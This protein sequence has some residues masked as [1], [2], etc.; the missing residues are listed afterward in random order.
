M[1]EINSL[2]V[3]PGCYIFKDDRKR[4]IYVGKAKNL[5]KRVKC[6]FQKNDLDIKT[7]SMLSR[8]ESLDFV[9]TDNE[10]EAL[11]LENT[12]IK[13]HQPRYNIRLKDAKSHSYIRLTHESFPRIL[14]ARR[15]VGEGKFYGPFV[16]AHERDYVLHFL[17]KTFALRTCKKMPKKPCLRYHIN[18]CD[19]PCVGKIDEKD[20]RRKIEKAKMVLSGKTKEL[21]NEMNQEMSNYSARQEFEKALKIRNELEAIAHL[22]ESQNMQ[23]EKKFN[24]D[25]INYK[26]KNEKVYLILFNI[27][28][29]ALSNKTEFIFDYYEGFFEEF[30]LQYYS[31]SPIPKEI[32]VPKSIDDTLHLFLENKKGEKVKITKPSK[33]EKKQLLDLVL[34]NIELSFFSDINKVEALKNRLKLNEDPLIIECFDIS[35]LSGSSTVGSMVQFRNGKPDK[36][37]YR[38]FKIRTVNGIDDFAAIAE[39]VRRRYFRLKNEDAELPQLIIIDGGRGQLNFALNELKNLDLK[40]PVVSIAKHFEEIYLPGENLP[41]R[42]SDKDKALHFIQEIRDEAHRF[43][44]KYNRLL[45][46][47]ELIS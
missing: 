43:A 33:G 45:R 42:L 25:I 31:D 27:Y 39:V 13:K 40:I 4:I 22:T 12:L 24:E 41:L 19:A 21:I 32:I 3:Y 7:Q 44:I 2:P 35:H 9:V 10:I 1:F 46:K 15:K 8:V 34:K 30:I 23:R 5:K 16:S 17:K 6:Y 11:I 36:N 47:K 28:K 20:Y 29:G 26:I 14:I 18:L 37:N 38:R